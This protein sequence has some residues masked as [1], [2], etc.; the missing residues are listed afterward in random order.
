[1]HKTSYG[2]PHRRRTTGARTTAPE[3]D[4]GGLYTPACPPRAPR[5]CQRAHLRRCAGGHCLARSWPYG[6]PWPATLGRTRTRG[7]SGT[8]TA[9]PAL[10]PRPPGGRQSS[11]RAGL[12]VRSAPPRPS[13]VDLPVAGGPTC[14]PPWGGDS[15]LGNGPTDAPTNR[16]QPPF[17]P[18]WGIPPEHPADCVAHREEVLALSQRPSAPRHPLVQRDAKP[19][20]RITET[21]APVPA[22]PG[23]PPRDDDASERVGT[24][25][26][27]GCPEPRTGWRT[28]DLSGHRPAVAWAPQLQPLRDD[29]A[30]TADT[31]TVVYAHLQPP[32]LASLSEAFAPAAARRL[33]RRLEIPDTPQ[34]G[35]WLHSAESARRVLTPP[36][37]HRRLAAIDT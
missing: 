31:V 3:R 17:H 21:R 16:L 23:Q 33:A 9:G 32:K 11:A 1:M 12:A 6:A 19:G 36:G 27:V 25:N 20:P 7:S 24:A 37:L 35:S 8:H 29:G 2:A 26:G 15:L 13:A 5:G 34:H 28:S 30:P 18:C 4:G 22:P 14:R 10:V